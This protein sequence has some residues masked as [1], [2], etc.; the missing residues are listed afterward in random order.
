MIAY[1]RG[2]LIR[3]SPNEAVIEA[4][5]VGYAATIP[6][7]TFVRLGEVGETVALHIHT[8]LTDDS[9]ALFGFSSPEEKDMF[10]KLIGISG[11][12]P[13]LAV[14][15]LSGIDP[16]NLEDAI[17][18]SDVARLSLVPGI[19]KKTALRIVMELQ[20]K[21]EDKERLIS[22]NASPEREDLVSALMNMGFK[23]KE[24]E[25]VVDRTISSVPGGAGFE[26]LLRE[27]LK[28]L[29]KI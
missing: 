13:K 7:S 6:L 12:G 24:V 21:L 2:T 19:G 17:R 29:A 16:Q 23:R 3:K 25:K 28:R 10:L 18:K 27:S 14:N 15:T 9:L 11:I 4:G 1:L 20:D 22:G 8:H 26:K 5:G